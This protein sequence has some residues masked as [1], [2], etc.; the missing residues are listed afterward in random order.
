MTSEERTMR[1]RLEFIDDERA[2]GGLLRARFEGEDEADRDV[3]VVVDG[4]VPVWA[5]RQPRKWGEKTKGRSV[6]HVCGE[7]VRRGT[8]TGTGTGTERKEKMEME[9]EGKGRR[10]ARTY[11][12]PFLFL[13]PK[14]YRHRLQKPSLTSHLKTP[15]GESRLCE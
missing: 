13:Y 7:G 6:F 10:E 12:E 8:G 9:G 3:V 11:L 2:L 14:A 1:E 15:I 5:R 4:G